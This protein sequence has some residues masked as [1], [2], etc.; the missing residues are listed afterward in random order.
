MC[1]AGGA[2]VAGYAAEATPLLALAGQAATS[3]TAQADCLFS[4][5]ERQYAQYFAPGSRPSATSAPYDYRYCPG[6]RNYLAT[7][8]VYGN[9][10]VLG[11]ISGGQVQS[12]GTLASFP[13][14]AG[15]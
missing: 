1:P 15:C 5:A 14:T 7:S 9:V 6:T 8:S 13:A 3:P 4:W 11:P 12:V 2:C 10:W